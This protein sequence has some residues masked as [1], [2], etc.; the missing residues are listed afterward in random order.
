MDQYTRRRDGLEIGWDAE[1]LEC[2]EAR[3]IEA[4]IRCLHRIC[5]MW[6]D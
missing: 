5:F 6:M 2:A 1:F 3:M 4:H